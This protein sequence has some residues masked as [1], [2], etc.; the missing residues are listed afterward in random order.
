MQEFD[1]LTDQERIEKLKNLIFPEQQ[2]SKAEEK[3]GSE[4]KALKTDD[5]QE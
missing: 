4:T 3:D 2:S 5:C 1:T